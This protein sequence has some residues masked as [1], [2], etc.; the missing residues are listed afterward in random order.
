VALRDAIAAQARASNGPADDESAYQELWLTLARRDWRSMV[1]VPAE[2]G[3]SA[4]AVA[5]ALAAVGTRLGPAPVT[6]VAVSSLEYGSA[7]AL[8]DLP[9]FVDRRRPAPPTGGPIVDLAPADV[10]E[11]EASEPVEAAEP[12]ARPG[13]VAEARARAVSSAAR[14]IFSVPSVLTEPLG[15]ATIQRADLV[16]LCVGV[17]HTGL[18]NARRTLELIGRERVAGCLMLR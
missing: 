6:V 2:P 5:R 14:L 4:E 7:L 16:V 9:A 1:L 12:V 8:A 10:Q 13:A 18:A 3:G 17:G 15:L 11:V